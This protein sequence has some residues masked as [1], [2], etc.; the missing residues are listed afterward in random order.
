LNQ[1]AIFDI[2][3]FPP[4]HSQKRI[5]TVSKPRAVLKQRIKTPTHAPF[6]CLAVHLG[7]RLPLHL[8][9]HLRVFLKHLRI[10]RE[11]ESHQVH[12]NISYT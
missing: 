6:V 4:P 7:Q 1:L 2:E 11:F 12:Q 8:Q 5:R 10:G 3:V 9:P